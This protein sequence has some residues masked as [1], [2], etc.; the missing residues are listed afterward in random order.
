MFCYM[1]RRHVNGGSQFYTGYRENAFTERQE[2]MW[3]VCMYTEHIF[4]PATTLCAVFSLLF[5]D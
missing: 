3:S 1:L 2:Y 5:V 4:S